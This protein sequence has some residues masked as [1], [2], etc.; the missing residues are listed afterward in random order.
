MAR[1]AGNIGRLCR[2]SSLIADHR[3]EASAVVLAGT[4]TASYREKE[5]RLLL[6]LNYA[7]PPWL[8]EVFRELGHASSQ[9]RC[10]SPGG[11]ASRQSSHGFYR[12]GRPKSFL[13]AF[14]TSP[15]VTEALVSINPC[16]G[17]QCLM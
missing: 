11:P 7:P 15:N 17:L 1:K 13:Q 5:Q 4:D 9:F 2:I 8:G 12:I 16:R 14:L 6:L 10:R 3:S